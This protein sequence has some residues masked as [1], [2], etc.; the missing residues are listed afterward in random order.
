MIN[1]NMATV[2][3]SSNYILNISYAENYKRA[4]SEN[5]SVSKQYSIK[6]ECRPMGCGAAFRGNVLPP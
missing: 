6:E 2:T 4:S 5:S 1:S 3:I